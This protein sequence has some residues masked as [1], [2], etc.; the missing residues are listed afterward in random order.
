MF[1]SHS[2]YDIFATEAH[3]DLESKHTSEW[4]QA[5]VEYLEK[6]PPGCLGNRRSKNSLFVK[7]QVQKSSPEGRVAGVQWGSENEARPAGRIH[8]MINTSDF[9]LSEMENH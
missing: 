5:A 8:T 7:L 4:D 1:I 2:V 6:E 3:I 9:T